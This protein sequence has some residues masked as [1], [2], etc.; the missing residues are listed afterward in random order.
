MNTNQLKKLME[1]KSGSVRA[2][3]IE[4]DIPYTTLRS[5]LERG[6]MNAKAETVFKIY[7]ILNLKPD[8]LPDTHTGLIKEI[9]D[10]TNQLPLTGQQKVLNFAKEQLTIQ[11]KPLYSYRVFERLSAGKGENFYEDGEF[12]TVYY[13]EDLTHDLASW[14]WG[15]SMEPK[16]LNGEVAL[17]K[18]NGFDYDGAVYAV[19]W[20]G[21]TFI[22]KVYLEE[23]G[24]RL[25]SLNP[26]YAPLFA[27][28]DEEPRIIGRVIGNFMPMER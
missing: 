19:S 23:E 21:Q 24:F 27:H 6:I 17:I 22:K 3:A 12:D 7:S 25:V 26:K 4:H 13:D 18:A 8:Y 10:T 5:I 11:N 2:F 1:T 9:I 28:K 14:I 15:D 16:F 20:A